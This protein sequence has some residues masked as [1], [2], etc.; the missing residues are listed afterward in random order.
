MTFEIGLVLVGFV[1]IGFAL[2]SGKI[3]GAIACMITCLVFWYAGVLTMEDVFK[4]FVSASVLTMIAMMIITKGLM[5]TDILRIIAGFVNK[6]KGGTVILLFSSMFITSLMVTFVGSQITAVITV[7]PL[8]MALA[9]YANV[10]PSVLVYPAVVGAQCTLFPIPM[11]GS[12][13]MYLQ[14]NQIME[15]FGA[16]AIFN[17]WDARWIA[18]VPSLAVMLFIMFGGHKLLPKR[19]L[20]AAELLEKGGMEGLAE[21]TLS[22]KKQYI[23]YAIFIGVMVCIMFARRLGLDTVQIAFT[24]AVLVYLFGIIDVKDF[25]GAINWNLIAMIAFMLS[26][27]AAVSNSGAGAYLAK[28][29]EPVFSTGN[30]VLCVVVVWIFCIVVTQFMDNMG[31]IN[32]VQPIVVS[33]AVANG[34]E[35]AAPLL[36]LVVS[37]SAV[38]SYLTPMGSP[39]GLFAYQLGGYKIKEMLKFGIP[40]VVITTIAALIWVPLYWTVFRGGF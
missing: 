20:G 18:F 39:A 35:K 16:P 3:N 19:E 31:L 5:K 37:A 26:F 21:S 40:C 8:V 15:T 29:L 14:H 13:V 28:I 10:S 12:A 27:I 22:K 1:F 36:F 11:G 7:I 24:G 17:M 23:M 9:Q 2:C 38:I 34:M 6:L 25:F 32:I 4:N 33:A 30:V